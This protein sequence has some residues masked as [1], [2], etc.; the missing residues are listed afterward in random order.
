MASSIVIV[1]ISTN[2]YILTWS[3]YIVCKD[4][5]TEN[6]KTYALKKSASMPQSKLSGIHNV[7]TGNNDPTGVFVVHG[8][9][10]SFVT[11]TS[12]PTVPTN[13]C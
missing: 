2:Q 1:H 10:I 7:F 13:Y 8:T 5:A 11:P 3:V 6:P 4:N 9:V 12:M